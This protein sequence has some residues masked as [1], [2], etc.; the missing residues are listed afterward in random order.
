[1]RRIIVVVG[2]GRSGSSVITRSLRVLGVGLGNNL[3]PAL[4]GVNDKGF[5]EDQDIYQLNREIFEALDHDWHSLDPFDVGNLSTLN[6]GELKA[7]AIDV[8]N[9]KLRT[10]ACFGVKDPQ[11]TRILPFW[12]E[13]FSDLKVNASYVITC[14]SPKSVVRSMAR[15]TGF[16]EA[17]CYLL[18]HEYVLASL[19]HT[20]GER[21]IVVDY[22]RMV[23]DPAA[24]LQRMAD[25]LNLSFDPFCREFSIYHDE[26]L[27]ESLRHAK[28]G[29]QDIHLDESVP[30]E[31]KELYSFLVD[32]AVDGRD[33]NSSGIVSFIVDAA[34]RFQKPD[35]VLRNVLVELESMRD[36]LTS[37][38]SALKAAGVNLISR[39]EELVASRQARD[40][41]QA[42]L[43]QLNVDLLERTEDLVTTR[44]ALSDRTELLEKVG[45]DLEQR[46]RELVEERDLVAQRT[47]QAEALNKELVERTE[48]LV[49]AR[50]ELSERTER[51]ENVSDD[52]K[53]RTG[54]LV[55]ARGL[56]AHHTEFI[57]AL[58]KE[59]AERTDLLQ[60]SQREVIA[61]REALAEKTGSL[62]RVS[63]QLQY[64]IEMLRQANSEVARLSQ[65]ILKRIWSRLRG[66]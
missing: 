25:I 50:L 45:S 19:L 9:E 43:T 10:T 49:V 1:M 20:N 63:E 62:D 38:R 46:T 14:R 4:A 6:R 15:Y 5:W 58:N 11:M 24:Q 37:H 17:K 22:D 29:Q 18:W 23:T 7:K 44:Y 54:E 66:R 47:S 52:L 64:H 21:R 57:E 32:L 2:S 41:Q 56:V 12:K 60:T 53:R 65:S 26:F 35:S 13:I 33:I 3:M 42:L 8:L 55:E 39:T 28:F 36:E 48:D 30:S 40:Q 27:E 34:A 16:N 51:L 31:V 61:A 59:L